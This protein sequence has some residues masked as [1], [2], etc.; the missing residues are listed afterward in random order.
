MGWSLTFAPGV[1]TRSGPG[2]KG[3][4]KTTRGV[5]VIL[6]QVQND[7]AEANFVQMMSTEPIPFDLVQHGRFNPF[8]SH[9]ASS[10]QN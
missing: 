2:R 9:S 10:D 5:I 7:N 1:P 6:N 4:W 8:H 3:L